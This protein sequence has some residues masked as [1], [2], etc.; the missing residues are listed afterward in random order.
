MV[1]LMALL[2]PESLALH[3]QR[4]CLAFCRIPGPEQALEHICL[5]FWFFKSLLG[6][7]FKKKIYLFDCAGS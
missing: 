4:P 1:T 7:F 5:F 6:Y 2:L 3:G